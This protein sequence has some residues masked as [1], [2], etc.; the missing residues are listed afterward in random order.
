MHKKRIYRIIVWLVFLIISGLIFY[1]LIYGER[2]HYLF[3]ENNMYMDNP[4]R[5][6]YVQIPT[7]R[8]EYLEEY[9]LLEGKE[10]IRLILLTYDLKEYQEEEFISE[11]K[12][13]ELREA[14]ECT[15]KEKVSIIFRAAYDFDGDNNEPQDVDMICNHITQ[16]AEVLNDYQEEIICIQAGM[17]GPWGEWHSSN[18]IDSTY[19]EEAHEVLMTWL[20]WTDEIE[21]ALRRPSYL[22]DAIR[23]GADESRLTIHNDALLST[24][25]DMGTYNDESYSRAEELDFIGGLPTIHMGGEMNQ[26]SEYNEATKAVDEFS[27]MNIS[28]LNRYYHQ[29]IWENWGTEKVEEENADDYIVKH[30]GYRLS[31]EEIEWKDWIYF[32][33]FDVY[34]KNTGFGE[35][36]PRYQVYLVIEGQDEIRVLELKNE[37]GGF[38]HNNLW[39]QFNQEQE[40][41]FGILISRRGINSREAKNNICLANDEIQ[42]IDGINYFLMDFKKEKISC[43]L[44]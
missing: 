33:Q 15:K 27:T 36:D 10:R 2:N 12:L 5:G 44:K 31:L 41:D 3:E 38:Y 39:H 7:D 24:D 40:Y 35:L 32:Q 11:Y 29:A 25:D 23:M 6:I 4:D 17:L 16:I 20:D 19:T 26:V 43:V 14:L 18:Y 28:Y 21:I 8:M 30:L 13:E 37:G 34:I 1:I 9:A 42:Y 22:R